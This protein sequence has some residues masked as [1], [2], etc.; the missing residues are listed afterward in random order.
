VRASKGAEGGR[1][2]Y[3]NPP[4]LTREA[5]FVNRTVHLPVHGYGP[6]DVNP[7]LL[8]LGPD[9]GDVVLDRP[10]DGFSGLGY[11]RALL[12]E[13]E[14]HLVALSVFGIYLA[15]VAFTVG[16]LRFQTAKSWWFAAIYA[17]LLGG[18]IYVVFAIALKL[19]LPGGLLGL[20]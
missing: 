8:G 1:V 5:N 14:Q 20:A 19:P 18:V 6:W 15:M 17:A 12:P 3:L 7:V 10:S 9:T 2:V 11:G 16:Y 4:P 13:A